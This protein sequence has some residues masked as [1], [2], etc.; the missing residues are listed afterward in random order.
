M[1]GNT[2]KSRCLEADIWLRI[3]QIS[4][5]ELVCPLNIKITGLRRGEHKSRDEH[6]IFAPQPPFCVLYDWKLKDKRMWVI[7]FEP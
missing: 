1:I 3:S 6:H 7:K 5:W 4:I 2:A